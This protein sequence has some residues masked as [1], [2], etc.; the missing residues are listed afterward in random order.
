MDDEVK[1]PRAMA[2]IRVGLYLVAAVL[3]VGFAGVA[4]AS[5][6]LVFV[7][8]SVA[9]AVTGDV[10]VLAV[11]GL[12]ALV[13]VVSVALFWGLLAGVQR[14]EDAV[15]E[16]DRKPDPQSV[17]TDRYVA[18]ELDERELERELEAL[19]AESGNRS[20]E[21]VGQSVESSEDQSVAD[22]EVTLEK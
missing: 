10:N 19:L 14:V 1:H 15:R 4:I 6:L 21:S 22:R 17:L 7:F 13:L 16:A 11:A 12:A 9:L 2:A 5:L 3:A 20:S 8:G 18:G